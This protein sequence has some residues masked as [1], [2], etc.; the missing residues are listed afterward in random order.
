MTAIVQ[1]C[2]AVQHAHP[3][4]CPK[5]GSGD[6]RNAFI[7]RQSGDRLLTSIGLNAHQSIAIITS[8]A[9]ITACAF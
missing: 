9:L 8:D 2:G 4:T 3:R 6:C 5:D 7:A 1:Y